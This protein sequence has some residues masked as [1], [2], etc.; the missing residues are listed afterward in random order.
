L[1]KPQP[2]LDGGVWSKGLSR[3]EERDLGS[4]DLFFT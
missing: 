2:M 4:Y 3:V 1:V